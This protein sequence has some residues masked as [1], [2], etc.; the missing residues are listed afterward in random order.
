[1]TDA[2]NDAV[3]VAA[4]N[5]LRDIVL[6]YGPIVAPSDER[7]N[8]DAADDDDNEGSVRATGNNNASEYSN[9][10]TRRAAAT[11]ELEVPI[12]F[13]SSQDSAVK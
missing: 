2:E 4:V 6:R 1:M 5:A 12:P 11:D 13:V 8:I 3:R 7:A 10:A 9:F